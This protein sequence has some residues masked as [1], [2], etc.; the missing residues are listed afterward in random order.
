MLDLIGSDDAPEGSGAVRVAGADLG[1][2]A[3]R[4][5]EAGRGMIRRSARSS[6]D[7]SD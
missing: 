3:A 5:Q 4:G 1:A 2:R 7:Q 6:V